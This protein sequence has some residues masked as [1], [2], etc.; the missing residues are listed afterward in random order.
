[1]SLEQI[2]QQAKEHFFYI[3]SATE[4]YH[5]MEDNHSHLN[6]KEVSLPQTIRFWWRGHFMACIELLSN[7]CSRGKQQVITNCT[8]ASA[9]GCS[10][11]FCFPTSLLDTCMLFQSFLTGFLLKCG[12]TKSFCESKNTLCIGRIW[13]RERTH[14]PPSSSIRESSNNAYQCERD[15]IRPVQ[16]LHHKPLYSYIS[17]D[18]ILIQLQ[19]TTPLNKCLSNIML[20]F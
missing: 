6:H 5:W 10:R 17:T 20:Q 19:Q 3:A 9:S 18:F 1:M 13:T 7:P 11:T 14:L 15:P 12:H 4:Q 16:S 8:S 2:H